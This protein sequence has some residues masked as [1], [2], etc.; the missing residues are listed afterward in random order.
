VVIA[1][2][3]PDDSPRASKVQTGLA[4]RCMRPPMAHGVVLL[5]R[6][7]RPAIIAV[8]TAPTVRPADLWV[9]GRVAPP[10]KAGHPCEHA[11]VLMRFW[12]DPAVG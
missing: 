6:G 3:D 8:R 7:T 10:V 5:Q 11:T 9:H 4:R 2:Y 1:G 12:W